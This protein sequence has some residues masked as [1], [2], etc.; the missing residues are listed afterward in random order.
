MRVEGVSTRLC[1]CI[2][3][4][5]FYPRMGGVE[6]HQYFLA[7]G[8]IRRGHKVILITGTYEQQRQ[9]IRYMSNGLKVYYCPVLDLVAQ[10][11]PPLFFSFFPLLREILIREQV[12]I[13]HGHQTTSFLAH[14]CILHAKTMGFRAVFTD[15]SLFGFADIASIHINKLMK[16]T[17]S[18]IDHVICV[19]HTAK[20]NLVLRAYLDPRNVSVIPNAVDYT[21]FTPDPGA[22][23][24]MDKQLNIVLLSRLV[25]RKGIDLAIEVIPEICQRHPSV[26]FI[27]GGD[28]PRRLQI[29]EMRERYQLHDRVELLG[30]VHHNDVRKVLT[31]GHIFL[32][33]SL[34]ESFC[35]AILEAVTCGLYTVST[36]VGGVGEVLPEEMISF[37]EPNRDDIIRA[38]QEAISNV[39]RVCPWDL[40]N[41]VKKMYS[42][43]NV[44]ARTERVYFQ[45]LN[46]PRAT[47]LQRLRRFYDCGPWAGKIFSAFVMFDLLIWRMLEWLFPREQVEKAYD[48]PEYDVFRNSSIWSQSHSK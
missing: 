33:C 47:F 9:G 34:T 13:V 7:Q 19:S 5:F 8:L 45:V 44:T 28:G 20:E 12:D 31:R 24:P 15:H 32:N 18:D 40:H 27:I 30:S 35:I 37:A 25:Y 11:S 10:A 14:E 36:R 22:A 46:Q 1:V 16:F 23:P 38:L 6:M 2:V 48:F 21:K 29:E 43:H 26:H 39:K 3:S 42:W 17:L 4:D 41:Q